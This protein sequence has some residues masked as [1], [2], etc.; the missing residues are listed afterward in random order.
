MGKFKDKIMLEVIKAQAE[1]KNRPER[2]V[3]KIAKAIRDFV[4][5]G[6]E[7][8]PVAIAHA[9]ATKRVLGFNAFVFRNNLARQ[10]GKQVFTEKDLVRIARDLIR[11]GKWRK[12]KANGTK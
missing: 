3:A 4:K 10:Y 7:L 9:R 11:S 5:E 12:E 8:D 2:E 1:R 6:K